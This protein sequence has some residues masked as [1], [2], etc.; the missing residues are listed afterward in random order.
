[1]IRR[2]FNRSHYTAQTRMESSQRAWISTVKITL[3]SIFSCFP[4]VPP[5]FPIENLLTMCRIH[6]EGCLEN[7]LGRVN[8]IIDDDDGDTL[9]CPLQ[10]YTEH[11]NQCLWDTVYLIISQ[12][13]THHVY[14]N[15]CGYMRSLIWD[16]H[17]YSNLSH[18]FIHPSVQFLTYFCPSVPRTITNLSIIFS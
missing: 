14:G 2:L 16:Q 1:M 7:A 8:S 3:I 11:V 10:Y 15:G 12:Y 4:H 13:L 18:S 5:I 6:L 9:K 17:F